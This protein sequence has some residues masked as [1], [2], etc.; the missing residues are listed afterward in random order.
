MSTRVPSPRRLGAPWRGTAWGWCSWSCAG[1]RM[2]G[3]PSAARWM[4]T[5]AWPGACVRPAGD[6]NR[7]LGTR[8]FRGRHASA[9]RLRFAQRICLQLDRARAHRPQ[10]YRA[11]RHL[12]AGHPRLDGLEM[13]EAAKIRAA[14]GSYVFF[15][16]TGLTN[17]GEP[18]GAQG[19][20]L[21]RGRSM[22]VDR[23]H[24][25][26]TPFFIEA[27]LPL[28]GSK[29]SS[30]FRRLMIA[31]DTGRRSSDRRAPTSI[32]RGRGGCSHRRPHSPSG[33]FRDA[34]A[35]RARYRRGC[36]RGALP[37]PRPRLPNSTSRK[38]AARWSWGTRTARAMWG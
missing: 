17:E 12:D 33:P 30:P 2:R 28:G 15:R 7:R 26:G 9:C 38:R 4:P 16:I 8:D 29:P 35:P 24:Q 25:Y 14:N 32:G 21:T 23:L 13:D 37:M 10:Y 22:A 20:P 11:Q 34:V 31:Q 6:P 27:N 1:S 36:A 18:L 3:T 19:V 5:R